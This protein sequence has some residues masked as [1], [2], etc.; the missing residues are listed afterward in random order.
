MRQLF[1]LLA[2]CLTLAAPV[3]AAPVLGE[4]LADTL[5]RNGIAIQYD[6]GRCR[7]PG[8]LGS[9]NLTRRLIT[10]CPAKMRSPRQLYE[11]LAHEA[12]HAAQHCAGVNTFLT[13]REIAPLVTD[14]DLDTLHL[15][16]PHERAAELE[17]N[18]LSRAGEERLIQLIDTAC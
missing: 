18:V 15:Y 16:Q 1:A 6:T 5:E 3:R 13:T 17:A 12:I 10:L 7:L 2:T 4:R 8:V 14:A 11:V 9:Y